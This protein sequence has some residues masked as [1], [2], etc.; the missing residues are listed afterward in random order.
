MIWILEGSCRVRLVVK[1]EARTRSMGNNRKPVP[2]ELR[3]STAQVALLLLGIDMPYYIIRQP[4]D[5]ISRSLRHLGEPLCF[6]LVLESIAREIY[7]YS[8]DQS[9]IHKPY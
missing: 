6:R 8:K 1:A 9:M 4:V 7:T 5:L 3:R 2:H